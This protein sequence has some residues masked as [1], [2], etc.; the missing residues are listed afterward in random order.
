MQETQLTWVLSLD[1]EAPLEEKMA[2]HC[3]IL[4]WITPQTEEPAGLQFMG[5]Q[6]VEHD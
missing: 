2:T 3:S 1:W 5:P 4:A 6:N